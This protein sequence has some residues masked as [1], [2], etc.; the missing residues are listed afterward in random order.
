LSTLIKV[1]QNSLI[2]KKG[3]QKTKRGRRVF[4]VAFRPFLGFI[5]GAGGVNYRLLV[6]NEKYKKIENAY[7]IFRD[8]IIEPGDDIPQID[9]EK[10]VNYIGFRKMKTI[11]LSI[12]N[13]SDFTRN[14]KEIIKLKNTL[15]LSRAYFRKLDQKYH[16]SGDDIFILQDEI[17][18]YG[19]MRFANPRKSL[20]LYHHQGSLKSEYVSLQNIKILRNY[21]KTLNKF[22]SAIFQHYEN[23]GFPSRG[24]LESLKRQLTF[25]RDMSGNKRVNILYNSYNKIEMDVSEREYFMNNFSYKNEL[26]ESKFKFISISNISYLKGI[27]QV[28]Q[29]MGL[30]KEKGYDFY[31][32]LIGTGDK[33][34]EGRIYKFILEKNMRDN[35][36]WIKA[37]IPNKYINVILEYTDFYIM[38]HRISV[39][40]ISTLEA[41]YNA[42]IPILSN[43]GGN[44]E[45]MVE[46]N[47]IIVN[48]MGD[49][50]KIGELLEKSPNE[51]NELK[52]INKSIAER[53]F[54]EMRFISRYADF[55]YNS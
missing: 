41:M 3:G 32:F 8:K 52:K 14:I 47:G 26:L 13:I 27:D 5:G 6:A 45:Y 28:A 42:N 54:S 48:D 4:F 16:F 49:I 31:W 51:I 33:D 43:V 2:N 37:R 23:W 29:V 11:F 1:V 22:Q 21:E 15:F 25:L 36:L 35:V 46:G 7:F 34:L 24:S 19:L 18:A 40:D 53:Y 55:V 20:F 9:E 30:I 44:P 12:F 17:S 38:L 50:Q 39:F 10:K